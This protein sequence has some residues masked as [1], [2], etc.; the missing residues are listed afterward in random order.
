MDHGHHLETGT[1]IVHNISY[2]LSKLRPDEIH[3]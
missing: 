3:R 1:I 2:D